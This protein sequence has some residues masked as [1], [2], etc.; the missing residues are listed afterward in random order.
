MF[1]LFNDRA[2]NGGNDRLLK[3][4]CE[5]HLLVAAEYFCDLLNNRLRTVGSQQIRISLEKVF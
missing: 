2:V 4:A 3:G 1:S 5:N